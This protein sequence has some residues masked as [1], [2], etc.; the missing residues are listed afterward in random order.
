MRVVLRRLGDRSVG[1]QRRAVFVQ[2]RAGE[3]AGTPRDLLLDPADE[4]LR[5]YTATTPEG[6]RHLVTG[7][8][9]E[10]DIGVSCYHAKTGAVEL[11]LNHLVDGPGEYVVVDFVRSRRRVVGR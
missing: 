5:R 7:E 10:A 6:V 8:F 4:V 2:C 9:D 1:P 3:D 11:W